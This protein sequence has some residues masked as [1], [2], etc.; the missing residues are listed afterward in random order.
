MMGLDWS[1]DGTTIAVSTNGEGNEPGGIALAPADGSGSLA[2]VAGTQTDGYAGAPTWS[3]DGRWISYANGYGGEIVIM[4]PDGSDRRTMSIDPGNDTIE[5]LA[6]GT[7]T[8]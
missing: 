2:F 5:E 1:P 4:R 7:A 8:R 6:W 3:P